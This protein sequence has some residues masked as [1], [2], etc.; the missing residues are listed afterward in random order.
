MDIFNVKKGDIV[1]HSKFGNGKVLDVN[2]EKDALKIL[3]DKETEGK[4]ERTI[5]SSH[6]LL[7]SKK[8]DS[9]LDKL[10]KGS[11]VNNSA[12]GDGTV[13]NV[14]YANSRIK[15]L[16][17]EELGGKRER[18][19]NVDF[20]R[21]LEDNNEKEKPKF[22]I[23]DKVHSE[24][25]GD[26]FV[27]SIHGYYR[28]SV[29]FKEQTISLLS[30]ELELVEFN[31]IDDDEI[32][33]EDTDSS[34]KVV[35]SNYSEQSSYSTC[36]KRLL[37]YLRKKYPAE[38]L[39]T[40]KSYSEGD[41]TFGVI[42]NPSYGVVV[43]KMLETEL[44]IDDLKS[45][46]I[47]KIMSKDL[48]N[49]K[50][51]YYDLFLQSKNLCSFFENKYK[52][53]KF[54]FKFV[55]IYQNVDILK[56]NK[57]DV[58][59]IK[60]QNKSIY[61]KN[62]NS[63]L[64]NNDLFENFDNEVNGFSKIDEKL[65]GSIIERVVPENATLINI[66]P[67]SVARS[68]KND[69]LNPQFIPI[70]GKERE[71]SALYL[72]DSQIKT[73]N[74]TKPGH[75]LTLANPGTGK[76][77]LLI[78]KAYR[79]QSK[80]RNNNA[81]ITCYNKN[82]AA[83]HLVFAEVS[84][85]KTANLRIQTFHSLILE[86]LNKK[87]P[88]FLQFHPLDDD[89]E[90]NFDKAVLR[91]EELIDSK[92][93]ETNLNAI[94]IDE[95]QLFDPKW[96]DVC[97]KLLDKSNNKD[98]YFEMFGDINQDVKSMRS[99][100]KASW[101]NT[102]CLPNLK[103]RVKKLD[104]NYRNT[105]LI[106]NYLKCMISEFNDYLSK[107]G[108]SIDLDSAGLTSETRKKGNLRTKILLSSNSDISKVVK[109]INELVQK[110]HADYNDIAIIYPMKKYGKYYNPVSMIEDEF[111]KNDIPFS[112]IHGDSRAYGR[113]ARKKIYEC[114]GVIMSTIDSC[115]GLDFKYVILCGM[116][117]WDFY[118]DEK[119]KHSDKLTLRKILFDDKAKYYFNEVGK[120][121]YSA[122]SRAREGLY[123]IDD[124]N[125]ESPIKDIIRPKTGGKYYDE[126]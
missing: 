83:H 75:Y 13:L 8:E 10:K 108:I 85:L 80:E 73:I 82:L 114:D 65:F 7:I 110:M 25:Y 44:Y 77:V 2:H 53:L 58:S 40:I 39:A 124:L 47:E 24:K 98:Y 15:V 116:H 51:Y 101:Q 30:D 105:D 115:L 84:G 17:D 46:I 45:S 28:V 81:L 31:I 119:E 59:K 106:S 123:I 36:A 21:L 11:R 70:T 76:S 26:G 37:T 112:F 126:Y 118:Y 122:C 104:V 90:G 50:K 12:F 54:P 9:L 91:V 5:K 19:M 32:S 63:L 60:I 100:G 16:F 121:I 72:D 93:I 27:T 99:K 18:E 29:K 79:I 56:F 6:L 125:D 14:D 64:P 66:A 120:K 34:F 88:K 69:S 113:E 78:S 3:F 20:L 1:S 74:D 22:K 86:L 55:Y 67:P 94:F 103:G 4:K 49:L 95:V 87:D 107:H 41:G 33:L 89:Y 111:E 62:F 92:S 43:F 97:Y 117:S 38:G 35:P 68:I 23:G 71:F 109:T 52:N 96:I 48:D 42:I 57:E 61:F 102:K